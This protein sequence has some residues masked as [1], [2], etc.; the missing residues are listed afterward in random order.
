MAHA[1]LSRWAVD[2]PCVSKLSNVAAQR[3]V[4][5]CC[6]TARRATYGPYRHHLDRQL[7]R[8]KNG[9]F[10]MRRTR[11]R[12]SKHCFSETHRTKCSFLRFMNEQVFKKQD[13]HFKKI[14]A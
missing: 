12:P 7:R 1:T 10:Q 4:P 5:V 9:P 3:A 6:L 2:G 14:Y 13:R 8:A 11:Y